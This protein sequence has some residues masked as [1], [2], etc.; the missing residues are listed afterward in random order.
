MA[1][2][3]SLIYQIAV[4]PLHSCQVK[5][6]SSNMSSSFNV[7]IKLSGTRTFNVEHSMQ[8]SRF[9]HSPIGIDLPQM[10]LV[11]VGLVFQQQGNVENLNQRESRLLVAIRAR[12]SSSANG[13]RYRKTQLNNS[14]H[15]PFLSKGGKPCPVH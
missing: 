1:V 2:G 5:Q 6:H 7:K 10:A 4:N 11:V 13:Q 9:A 14:S 15:F 3:Q 12:G 8:F